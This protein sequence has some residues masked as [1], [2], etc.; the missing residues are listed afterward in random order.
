LNRWII[1]FGVVLVLALA[2]HGA[3]NLAI[4]I[5]HAVTPSGVMTQDGLVATGNAL[6]S[7]APGFVGDAGISS[8][9]VK[10]A[11]TSTIMAVYGGL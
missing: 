6:T 8:A 4:S 5:G 9:A 3:V 11:T 7:T 1:R 2:G 10:A